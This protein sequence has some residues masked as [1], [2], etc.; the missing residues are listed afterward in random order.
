MLIFQDLE[1]STQSASIRTGVNEMMTRFGQCGD[2]GHQGIAGEA[3]AQ[4]DLAPLIHPNNVKEP[5][6]DVNSEYA[7]MG[8]H[9]TR[10]LWLH[11]FT[12]LEIILAH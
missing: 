3:F 9:R 6:C 12:G 11:G 10:L 8:F 7:H 1:A 5:L 4:D 2:E